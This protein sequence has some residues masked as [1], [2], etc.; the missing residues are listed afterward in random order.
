MLVC[1]ICSPDVL[2]PPGID[3]TMSAVCDHF[4]SKLHPLVNAKYVFYREQIRKLLHIGQPSQRVLDLAR[5]K[6]ETAL[7]MLTRCPTAHEAEETAF[8]QAHF[9]RFDE[10]QHGPEAFPVNI[11]DMD[12][13]WASLGAPSATA[14]A[15]GG[16]RPLSTL[17]KWVTS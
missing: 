10:C 12:Q 5:A 1:G 17:L 9:A 16:L 4:F 2:V 8:S 13:H 11:V 15:C 7:S 14:T 3:H 6:A